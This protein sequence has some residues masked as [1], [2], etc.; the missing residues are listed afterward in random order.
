MDD[1]LKN[2]LDSCFK[3]SQLIIDSKY[4]TQKLKDEARK[5]QEKIVVF[6][7][8]PYD[9]L[10]KKQYELSLKGIDSAIKVIPWEGS[11]KVELIEDVK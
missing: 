7:N 5:I 11:F 4:A 1:A 10:L 3:G 8:C 2:L 6:K 9:D